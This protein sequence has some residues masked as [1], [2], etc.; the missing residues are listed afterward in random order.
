MKRTETGFVSEEVY[1]GGDF[2]Q[3]D[4]LVKMLYFSF[5]CVQSS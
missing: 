5:V 3:L 1:A 4:S 2:V